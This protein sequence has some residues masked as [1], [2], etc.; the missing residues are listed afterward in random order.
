MRYQPIFRLV[1]PHFKAVYLRVTHPCATSTR[2]KPFPVRL[3]CIRHAASVCSE[4]ESNSPKKITSKILISAIQFSKN[5]SFRQRRHLIFRLVFCQYF[6]SLFFDSERTELF[7]GGNRDRT[8]D[9]LNANQM[10]S[11]LSY[12]PEPSDRTI[13]LF[14]KSQYCSFVNIFI[15]ALL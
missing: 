2:P 4:P 3:A 1:I 15:T 13:R 7:G 10:L 8:C 11:Q 12:T 5:F 6:F 14:L 9:L